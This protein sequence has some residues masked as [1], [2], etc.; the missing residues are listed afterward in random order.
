MPGCTGYQTDQ[1]SNL[2]GDN[3]GMILSAE[4]P[5][6]ELKKKHVAISYHYVREAIAHQICNAIWVKLREKFSD[7]CT[8]ALGTNIFQELTQDVMAG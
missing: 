6:G 1:F 7:I 5:D 8:K 2:Y 4:I 3:F